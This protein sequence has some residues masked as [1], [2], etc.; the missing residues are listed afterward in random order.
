M[1]LVSS[2]KQSLRELKEIAYFLEL[3]SS[4][5]SMVSSSSLLC[6][7]CGIWQV[8]KKCSNARH[9]EQ[10]QCLIETCCPH[11]LSLPI[12]LIYVS[13]PILN[14]ILL[15][16]YSQNT[17]FPRICSICENFR[18]PV[19]I[20]KASS[21]MTSVSVTDKALIVE[22]PGGFLLPEH[23]STEKQPQATG[24]QN[25]PADEL[26]ELP[27]KETSTSEPNIEIVSL[28]QSMD[29]CEKPTHQYRYAG[30]GQRT[31]VTPRIGQTESSGR[32]HFWCP[33]LAACLL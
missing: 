25:T 10:Q 1:H 3:T 21:M 28:S 32:Q 19:G 17:K 26:I 31:Q 11:L 13:T 14:D 33:T 8:G 9:A 20:K 5:L 2:C 30:M 12:Y 29:I 16:F 24:L 4:V 15:L 18:R 22:S 7:G 27:T 23:S 6:R